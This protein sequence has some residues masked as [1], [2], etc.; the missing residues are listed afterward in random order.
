[1]LCLSAFLANLDAFLMDCSVASHKYC[2][3]TVSTGLHRTC[4]LQPALRFHISPNRWLATA[5]GLQFILNFVYN[6]AAPRLWREIYLFDF[7][8]LFGEISV[9]CGTC[10][11]SKPLLLQTGLHRTCF[12]QPALRFHI[13]PNRWLVTALGLQFILFCNILQVVVE[14]M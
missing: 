12:L 1:M 11:C 7:Y 9:P 13:S 3:S 14:N 2:C 8:T 4:F 5:L 10:G 6:H